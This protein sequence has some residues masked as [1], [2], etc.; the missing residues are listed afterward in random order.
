M[1]GGK[2]RVGVDIFAGGFGLDWDVLTWG[3]RG[4]RGGEGKQ[5]GRDKIPRV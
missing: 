3:G 1:C 2:G 4:L 5:A